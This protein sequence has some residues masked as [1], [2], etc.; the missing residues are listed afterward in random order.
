MPVVG[1]V[2]DDGNS[3]I[4][5]EA[6]TAL[7][8]LNIRGDAHRQILG[9]AGITRS[10]IERIVKDVR[11]DTP[12]ARAGLLL[13]RIIADAPSIIAG[14]YVS[15]SHEETPEEYGKRLAQRSNPGIAAAIRKQRTT[16]ITK[17]IHF[18]E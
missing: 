9:I 10:V 18:G 4:K 6:G 3:A 12:T 5:R 8:R 13:Q 11:C 2:G 14:E 1:V 16:S 15:P 7:H 17:A